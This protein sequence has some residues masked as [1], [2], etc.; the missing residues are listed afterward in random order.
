MMTRILKFIICLSLVSF[1]AN[2]NLSKNKNFC[3]FELQGGK[4]NAAIEFFE[5]NLEKT[6]LLEMQL[7]L[8]FL[9]V[10]SYLDVHKRK[11]MVVMF[12][13]IKLRGS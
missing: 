7:Y 8:Q 3:C 5:S 10:V 12:V 11:M 13:L 1:Q 6:C 4:T 9:I 2:A